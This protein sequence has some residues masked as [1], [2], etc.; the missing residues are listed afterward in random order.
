[1]IEKCTVPYTESGGMW[2]VISLLPFATLYSYLSSVL[3]FLRFVTVYGVTALQT[4]QIEADVR[5]DPIHPSVK[6]LQN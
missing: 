6:V 4:Y 2:S 5:R 3:K 1:M